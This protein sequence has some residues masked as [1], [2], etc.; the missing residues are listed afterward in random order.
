MIGF[1]SWKYISELKLSLLDLRAV[2]VTTLTDQMR[3]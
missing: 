3:D 1:A 2:G